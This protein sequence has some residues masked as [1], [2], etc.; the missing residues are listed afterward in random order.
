MTESHQ[1]IRYRNHIARLAGLST[2]RPAHFLRSTVF[3]LSELNLRLI[4]GETVHA[5]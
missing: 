1:N 5:H 3:A 2:G 4:K